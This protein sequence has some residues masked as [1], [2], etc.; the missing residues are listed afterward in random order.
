MSLA[1][2]EHAEA[3]DEYQAAAAWYEAQ[4]PGWGDVFMDA[5]DAAIKSILDPSIQ[6]GYYRRQRR[7]TQVYTRG[8]AGFP[9]SIIYLIVDGQVYIVAYA[10]ER[11]R[12]NYWQHRVNR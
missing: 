7:T 6:W 3:L 12:P 9:F 5:A 2:R 8:I 10:H 1:W 11:R 4:R